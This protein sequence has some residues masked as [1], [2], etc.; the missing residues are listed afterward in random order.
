MQAYAKKYSNLQL[1]F[2]KNTFYQEKKISYRYIVT[3]VLLTPLK[4]G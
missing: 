3:F 1:E 2:T 4:R